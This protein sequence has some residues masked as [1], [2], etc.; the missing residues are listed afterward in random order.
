[1]PAAAT[2]NVEKGGRDGPLQMG[3]IDNTEVRGRAGRACVAAAALLPARARKA[4]ATRVVLYSCSYG[5]PAATIGDECRPSTE[6]RSRKA[7]EVL[8]MHARGHPLRQRSRPY[9]LL[10]RHDLHALARR[11]VMPAMTVVA[12]NQPARA[13]PQAIHWVTPTGMNAFSWPRSSMGR[14]RSNAYATGW[15]VG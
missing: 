14:M 10:R 2:A 6:E 7:L 4:T 11:R 1:M 3:G 15:K 5:V 13:L 8:G 12:S 9:D